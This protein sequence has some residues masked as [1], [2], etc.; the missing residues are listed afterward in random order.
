MKKTLSPITIDI[1]LISPATGLTCTQYRLEIRVWDGLKAAPPLLASYSKTVKNLTASTGNYTVNVSR[2]VNDFLDLQPKSNASTALIDGENQRWVKTEVFYTTSNV[3]EATA[4]QSVAI[5]IIVK[6][7]TYGNE[8]ANQETPAN[9]NLISYNEF[10]V[11]R[12]G[13]F[14]LP[15]EIDE[16]TAAVPSLTLSSVVLVSGTTYTLTFVPVGDYSSL[17]GFAVDA[18]VVRYLELLAG[19]TSTRTIDIPFTGS[20]NVSIKGFDNGTATDIVSNVINISI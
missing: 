17:Y 2:L 12:T 18:G 8:G 15:I 10:N 7:Y 5:N 9:K 3:S 13:V 20:V 16:S 19:V 4:P 6:G 14:V 1:P 11:S